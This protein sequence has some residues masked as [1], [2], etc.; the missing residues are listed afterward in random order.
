MLSVVVN[1]IA[2]LAGGALGLLLKKG[3]PERFTKAI[4][5]GMGLV[6]LYIGISGALQGENPIILVVAVA[7][8]AAAGT[9]IR[10]DDR[11]NTLGAFIEKKFSKGQADGAPSIAQG[12]VT[13]S[14]LF[15]V[16]AMAI[17][18]SINSGLTGDHSIIFT[19]SAIDLISAIFLTVSLGFGVLFSAGAVFVYQG[20]L[21][22]LAH[23]LR[24]LLDSYS[25]IAEITS[26]G[27]LIIVALGFNMIGV[28]KIKVADLLPA[29]VVVPLIY[30]VVNL[31]I[32]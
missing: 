32:G 3:V 30:W 26:A 9:A 11:L 27:S 5:T 24:P 17:V 12:F 18:G 22:L 10:V 25:L 1:T 23:L 19:K 28:T 2:I 7:L 13:S 29:V 21:V 15:C 20:A 8:G 4:M 6:V 16:G 14:L 31:F